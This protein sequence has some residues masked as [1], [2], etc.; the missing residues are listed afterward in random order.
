MGRI[1]KFLEMYP[2]LYI[3]NRILFVSESDGGVAGEVAANWL[4]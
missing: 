4:W 1:G 3:L 2:H